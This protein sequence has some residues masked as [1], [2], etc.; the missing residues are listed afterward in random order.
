MTLVREVM[1]AGPIGLPEDATLTDAAR[2]MRSKNVGALFTFSDTGVRGLVT[3]RDIVVRGLAQGMD[4]DTTPIQDVATESLITVQGSASTE[5]AARLM[6]EHGV[7]RLPV[8]E[9]DEIVGLLSVD[10][11]AAA[12]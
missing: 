5:E 12:A 2:E 1:T 8:V 10:D 7:R 3:D 4:P 11:L 9:D 6:R